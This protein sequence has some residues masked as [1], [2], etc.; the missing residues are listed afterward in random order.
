MGGTAPI[1]VCG[2]SSRW[3][4]PGGQ[5]YGPIDSA[6]VAP[7]TAR[8]SITWTS[9]GSGKYYGHL[10]GHLECDLWYRGQPLRKGCAVSLSNASG[11]LV[12]Q[13]STGDV[14]PCDVAVDFGPVSATDQR[15]GQFTA[16]LYTRV[17]PDLFIERRSAPAP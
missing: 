5:K 15:R 4:D 9:A 6:V 1:R 3:G 2:G 12:A 13:D 10:S 17:P 8:Q 11:G 16:Q 14:H 7:C